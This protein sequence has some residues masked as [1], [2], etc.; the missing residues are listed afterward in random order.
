[1]SAR[2]VHTHN[3]ILISGALEECFAAAA[4]VER[5][6]EILPHYREVRFTNRTG[7]VQTVLMKARRDFGPIPYP[8]WWESEMETD[9]ARATVRYR[10][11]AGVTTGMDVEWRLEPRGAATHVVITHDW[12]GPDWPL[13]GDFAARRIICPRFVHVV[14][15]RTLLGIKRSVESTP[16]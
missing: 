2:N 12:T 16:A 15:G 14:A 8:I 6:P 3:E 5:W 9:E 13:I 7:D 10:H 11:V 1:V 4:D